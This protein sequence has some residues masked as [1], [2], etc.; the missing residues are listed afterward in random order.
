MAFNWDKLSKAQRDYPKPKFALSYIDKL[1]KKNPGNPYLTT[2]RADVSLQLQSQPEAVAKSLQDVCQHKSTLQDEQLLQYA[3]R[4]IV[5]ATL[6]S[7]PQLDRISTVGNEGV[8]AWQ[9]AAGLKTTK[10]DRKDIWNALFTTAM[11]HGCWD[12]VRTAIVK[13]RAEGASSDKLTYYTQIFAQQMSA[14]QKIRASQA[15][16]VADRMAEI[17][18]G[19]ALKQM[20]D[21][22]ERPESD[23]ISVKDI[24]DLRF[25]AKIYARQGKCAELL[26]LWKA[27]PAH[28][29][30]VVEKHALD[31]SL[32]TVDM[33]A[34]AQQHELLENHILDLIEN[35][36]TSRSKDDS[37]PL[38]Q[39]CSARA[40]IWTYLLDASTKLYS[41]EESKNKIALV[42]DRV[43]APDILKLDRPLCLV[44]LILRIYLGESLLQDCKDF[45]KQFS[46][47][48]SCFTDLRRAVE[49]MSDQGRADFLTYIE[50]DMIAT[51]PSTED[52]QSKLEEWT[53]AEICVLKFTYLITVSLTASRPSTE[54]LESLVERA[55]KVSQML[56]KDPDP[57]MLIAYCL[58]NMHHQNTGLSDASD[59]NSRFLLQATMLVRVAVERDTEKENRPLALLAARLHLSLGLGRVAF[60]L[61]KHV[62]V[63]EMLVDTLS[64]YLLSRVALTQPFDVQHHQGFSADK[65]LKHVVD[66]IDRMRKVQED[67]IFRDIKR[68]HWDS[69]MDLISM[70][71]KLTSSLTRHASILERRRIGRLKGEPAGDLPDVHH[72]SAQSVSDNI[73]R[74]VFPAYEHS[75][76][77]RPYSFLMPADIP[78]VDYALTHSHNR[79]SVS[80]ILFREGLP[81]NWTPSAAL[82]NTANETAA[83]RLISENF[84]HPTST[85]LYSA[86]N[87]DTKVDTKHFTALTTHLAQLRQD[88]EKLIV[89]TPTGADPVDEPTMIHENQLIAAYSALEALRALL[90]LANEIKERVVQSKTPHPMKAQVPKDWAKEIDAEVKGAFE[91]IGRVA[92]SYINLLQKRGVVA[93]KAQVRWGKTGEALRELV[94]EDDVEHYARE[95]AD[96]AV[97]AWKGVLAVKLK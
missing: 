78:S 73:D 55:S 32:L 35:A 95:Y 33:L 97:E 47:I 29:Q 23:P 70:N 92:N 64:P 14:E 49:K 52:S 68:F 82:S 87:P 36:I 51:K 89:S 74:S 6:R 86:L 40:N 39:L 84:W 75:D 61:W 69:A 50:E 91:A 65:E 15:T 81:S 22:Y 44:R 96:A 83:E 13:Y 60:Q 59:L 42:K 38:R 24:R 21:A 11:R 31:I 80:K 46:R 4:L 67:L 57:I 72:R 66:T 9:N 48:P 43:F 28:L 12:D 62:K 18:L 7:N 71:E 37:E 41:P 88:Q 2:W 56:P 30:P 25:M 10:K 63:K 85:L 45:W 94:S 54:T 34:S 53:R 3:Y 1:L 27:P 20:K 90:R 8:K 58:N 79:E 19:V 26:K 76:V 93:I 16:G 17:Q 5:E 77:H